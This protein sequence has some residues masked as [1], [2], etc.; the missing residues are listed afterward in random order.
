MAGQ[1]VLDDGQP[2]PGALLSAACL[3]VDPVEAL[4]DARDV[5]ARQCRDR[6]RCTGHVDLRL[7]PGHALEST[8]TIT[9]PPDSAIF[10]GVLNQVFE[11]LEEFVAIAGTR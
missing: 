6:N 4:G 1:D 9:L 11:H 3:G 2:K 8:A 10:A 7:R 5:L